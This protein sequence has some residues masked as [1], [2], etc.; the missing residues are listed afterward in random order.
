MSTRIGSAW[1]K[2][3]E[4]SGV[5]D[6]KQALSLKIFQCYV[7]PTLLSTAVKHRNLLLQMKRDCVGWSVA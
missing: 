5:L 3:R 1:K 2:F 4:L 7:R 6:G